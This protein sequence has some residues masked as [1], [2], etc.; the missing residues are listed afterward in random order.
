MQTA[1]LKDEAAKTQQQR[2]H[3]THLKNSLKHQAL[4]TTRLHKTITF[5]DRAITGFSNT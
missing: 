5:R 1:D 4:D 2:A 3:S